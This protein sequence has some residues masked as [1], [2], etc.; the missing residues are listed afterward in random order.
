LAL[1]AAASAAPASPYRI[2][3]A[4]FPWPKIGCDPLNFNKPESVEYMSCTL[5]AQARKAFALAGPD[6][7]HGAC[8]DANATRV[9]GSHAFRSGLGGCDDSSSLEFLYNPATQNL[10]PG[11]VLTPTPAGLRTLRMCSMRD[12]N[13]PE[14]KLRLAVGWSECSAAEYNRVDGCVA[15]QNVTC[16]R[17]GFEINATVSDVD[18]KFEFLKSTRST[19]ASVYRIRSV[20]NG[21]CVDYA[22]T[23]PEEST[24]TGLGMNTC[25]DDSHT[26]QVPTTWPA[27]SN[28]WRL[29]VKM[30]KRC[31]V[32]CATGYA[33]DLSLVGPDGLTVGGA[34]TL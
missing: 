26:R 16:P 30:T 23:D 28:S 11:D 32:K 10:V 17:S 27:R 7:A 18:A 13:Y 4:F 21:R 31:L 9:N 3:S 34:A 33:P 8:I 19:Y 2:D 25:Y 20:A 12:I 14:P 15:S 29:Y 5:V 24:F 6:A 1:L 22:R